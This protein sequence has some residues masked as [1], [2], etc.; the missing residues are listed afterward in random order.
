MATSAEIA[1]YSYLYAVVDKRNFKKVTAYIRSA[2][3]LGKFFGYAVAQ[4]IVT[5]DNGAYLL[6]NQITLASVSVTFVISL[7]LQFHK[8]PDNTLMPDTVQPHDA[9]FHETRAQK[10]VP[11]MSK[12][13]LSELLE[14]FRDPTVLSWSIWWALASCGMYQ[15]QN[16]SQSLWSPMHKAGQFMGNGVMECITT[17]ST[18]LLTFGLQYVSFNWKKHSST[19]FLTTSI[20]SSLLLAGMAFIQNIFVSYFFYILNSTLYHVLIAAASTTIAAQLQSSKYSLIFGFNTFVALFL[21]TALTFAVADKHGMNLPIITQF[22]VYS[23]YFA[24]LALLFVPFAIF[25][26][27]FIPDEDCEDSED[28]GEDKGTNNELVRM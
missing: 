21:Q 7:I 13:V 17:L 19:V 6:L 16:Y 24:V 26:K 15:V 23:G 3:M 22:Y 10:T 14:A 1:Y 25:Q 4:I 2:V 9:E 20:F 11:K 8:T 5:F 12:N 27:R 18:T 28:S